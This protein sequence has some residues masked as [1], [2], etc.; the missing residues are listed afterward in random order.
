MVGGELER[1]KQFAW[2]GWMVDGGWWVTVPMIDGSH[3]LLF[4]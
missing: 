3:Y 2:P 4:G 1:K